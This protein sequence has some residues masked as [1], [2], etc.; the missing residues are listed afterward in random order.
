MNGLVA[1]MNRHGIWMISADP[2]SVDGSPGT[3]RGM[4]ARQSRFWDDELSIDSLSGLITARLARAKVH[5]V[6]V[7]LCERQRLNYFF[8]S[9]IGHETGVFVRDIDFGTLLNVLLAGTTSSYYIDNGIYIFGDAGQGSSCM[10]SVQIVHMTSRS[11]NK[12]EEVIPAGLKENVVIQSFPDLNSIIISGEQ[13]QV[14]R[15][16]NFIRSID[17]RVPMITIEIMIVDVTKNNIMEAGLGLGLGDGGGKTGGTLSPGINMNLNAASVNNIISGFNGFGS[18]SL[19]KVTPQFYADI[20]LLE[21][22]GVLQLRSTPKLSTLNGQEATLKSGETRY[23][24][25]ITNNYIGYQ[26]PTLTENYIWKSIDANLSV[27]IIPFVSK[28][29]T[30]TLDIEIEQTEFVTRETADDAPPATATR[31]FKSLIKVENN[32]MVLLGG[33]DRNTAEKGSKGLPFIARVPVLKW[34][35]GN[36]KNNKSDQRLS[37][38]IKPTVTY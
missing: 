6:I 31:S 37:V 24:K 32:D 1:D 27:R 7:D 33:I 26:N 10:T 38:F 17:K 11:V 16:A 28:D 15:A 19:G 14:S 5:D 18:I 2:G 35:F 20:K 13:K 12:V 9:Q 29:N 34:I 25:E 22:N 36:M 21:E 4:L 3:G 23:Y 30:I 8:L